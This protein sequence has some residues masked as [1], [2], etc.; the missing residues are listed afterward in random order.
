VFMQQI[1]TCLIHI[2]HVHVFTIIFLFGEYLFRLQV[3]KWLAGSAY[4]SGHAVEAGP[5]EKSTLIKKKTKFSLIWKEIHMGSL[6]IY[7]SGTDQ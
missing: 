3:H 2:S 4:S 1:A 7:D 6:V 5:E